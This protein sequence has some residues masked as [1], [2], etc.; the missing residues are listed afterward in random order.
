MI[1]NDETNFEAG[2]CTQGASSNRLDSVALLAVEVAPDLDAI[3]DH[4]VSILAESAARSSSPLPCNRVEL[5]GCFA[6]H[7]WH[8]TY[9]EALME[10]DAAKLRLLITEA[11]KAI[12]AR[13]LQLS[14]FPLPTDETL[15]LLNAVD[16]L[17]NLR[18]ATNGNPKQP[19]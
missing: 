17:A 13:Y 9:A 7:T 18:K 11:E 8:R 6:I 16:A 14:E 3:T 19:Q 1:P 15:D 12:L 4:R 10:T 5:R 2:H